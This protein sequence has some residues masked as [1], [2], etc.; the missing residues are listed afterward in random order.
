MLS[1]GN[2]ICVVYNGWD[3]HIKK[4]LDNGRKNYLHTASVTG[5]NLSACADSFF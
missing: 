3:V 5:E 2:I 4:V 1:Q